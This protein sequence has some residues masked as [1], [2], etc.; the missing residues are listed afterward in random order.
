MSMTGV[1]SRK[2]FHDCGVQA[3]YRANHHPDGMEWHWGAHRNASW[4]KPYPA[5]CWIY[6]PV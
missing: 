1:L 6:P 2:K 5:G 3:I 4:L